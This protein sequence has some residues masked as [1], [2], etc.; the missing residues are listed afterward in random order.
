M[1]GTA[2]PACALVAALVLTAAHPAAAEPPFQGMIEEARH[3][4]WRVLCDRLDHTPEDNQ[5]EWGGIAVL[6]CAATPLPGTGPQ[7]HLYQAGEG[8][9]LVVPGAVATTGLALSPCLSGAVPSRDALACSL[10]LAP[11]D[12]ATRL[13]AAVRIDRA[14]LPRA[15]L[16]EAL[17]AMERLVDGSQPGR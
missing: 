14:P 3:G 7:V 6:D 5:Q 12:W 10:P 9:V 13:G 2:R 16:A 4:A 8:V 17:A 11:Q 15:G 1:S